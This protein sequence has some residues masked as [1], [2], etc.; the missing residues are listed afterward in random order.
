M[1]SGQWQVGVTDGLHHV[2]AI[3]VGYLLQGVAER[4]SLHLLGFNNVDYINY[5]GI[6]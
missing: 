1:R 6:G 2:A 5:V 4:W 3:G